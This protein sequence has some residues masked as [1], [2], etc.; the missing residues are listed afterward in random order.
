MK[1]TQQIP[2]FPAATR[3]ITIIVDRNLESQI[4]LKSVEKFD[5]ELIEN[6]HLFDVYEGD[7]IPPGKKSITFRIIYRSLNK[8]LEDDEINLVHKTIAERLL[9]EFDATLPI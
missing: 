2:K 5:E 8:T 7:P 6:L 4:I 9:K 3:D 1:M